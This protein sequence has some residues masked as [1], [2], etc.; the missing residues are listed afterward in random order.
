LVVLPAD[1]QVARADVFRETL[2][3]AA[4][5]ARHHGSLVLLGETPS[6]PE[7]GFGYIVRGRDCGGAYEVTQFVEK[8]SKEAA[9]DL[10]TKGALWNSGIFLFTV[11]AIRDA[12]MA[13]LP[14]V[15]THVDKRWNAVEPVSFDRG[16]LEKS[17]EV[18]VLPCAL[19]WDDLGTWRAATHTSRV[20]RLASVDATNIVIDAPGRTVALLGVSDLVIVDTGDVLLVTSRDHAHRVDEVRALLDAAKERG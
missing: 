4:A 19:G 12:Y 2:L 16:I 8:P 9:Q 18:A 1:H 13:F 20:E 15:W 11:A 17:N 10:I 7:T 6:R 5:Q 3:R 14:E